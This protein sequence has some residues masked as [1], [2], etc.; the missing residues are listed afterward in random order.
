MR[1]LGE[2]TLACPSTDL[3]EGGLQGDANAVLSSGNVYA[4][5]SSMRI[6]RQDGESAVAAS[7]LFTIRTASLILII[8]LKSWRQAG[9]SARC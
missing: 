7:G 9:H 6:C 3:A 1:E 4:S 2:P 5:N 8:A